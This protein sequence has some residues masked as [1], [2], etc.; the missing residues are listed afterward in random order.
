MSQH[1]LVNVVAAADAAINAEDYD[2][3]MTFMPTTR[4]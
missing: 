4:H 2:A 1:D 3:I